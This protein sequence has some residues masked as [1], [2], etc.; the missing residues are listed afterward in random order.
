MPFDV[1]FIPR[2]DVDA[3]KQMI[4]DR[5]AAVI[6]E[7]IQGVAGAFALDEEFVATLRARCTHSGAVLIADEVQSGMGRSGQFFAVQVFGVEPDILTCAKAL[8]GGF[9]CGAV[10]CNEFLS[11]G[12]RS[13]ALGSTFGGGP[14]AA[15]AIL[16]V[17]ESI[18][19]ENLL[20]NVRAREGEIRESCVV[21]PVRRIQ[22]MGLLLGLVCDRPASEVQNAL[23]EYDIL[24]GPSADPLVLRL[25]P[26]LVLESH[27]VVRLANTLSELAPGVSID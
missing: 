24:T 9:P 11:G 19:D 23:L 18:R 7:P 1:G 16:A 22:G 17:I 10:L 20:A 2:N 3:A 8:G 14:V 25:L 26:P 13:G 4:D 27:H 5:V 12:L 15:A 6:F 21:G